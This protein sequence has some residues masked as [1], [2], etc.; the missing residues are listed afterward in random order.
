MVFHCQRY[1][2]PTSEEVIQNLL[3]MNVNFCV[4]IPLYPQYSVTSTL[5]SLRELDRTIDTYDS[6]GRIKWTVIQSFNSHPSYLKVC[7][8][9]CY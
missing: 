1:S 3:K 6:Y 5:S 2:E 7:N 8:N 4:V 9:I